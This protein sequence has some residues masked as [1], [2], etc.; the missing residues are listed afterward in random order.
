MAKNEN[1]KAINIDHFKDKDR[2]GYLLPGIMLKPNELYEA[3]RQGL[4]SHRGNSLELVKTSPSESRLLR[5]SAPAELL[6]AVNKAELLEDDARMLSEQAHV[7]WRKAIDERIAFKH[8]YGDRL[9]ERGE[10]QYKKLEQAIVCAEA[11]FKQASDLEGE[12]RVETLQAQLKLDAWVRSE[13]IRKAQPNAEEK[14][15]L[16]PAEKLLMLQELR[17]RVIIDH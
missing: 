15:P 17:E 7:K 10:A 3:C 12:A 5:A 4:R 1:T 2:P 16:S 6:E 8:H 14:T 11:D 9:T 13:T